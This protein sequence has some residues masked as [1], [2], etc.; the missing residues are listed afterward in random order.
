[1][2]RD[3]DIRWTTHHFLGQ[4]LL[5]S[6]KSQQR[7][8]LVHKSTAWWWFLFMGG[9]LLQTVGQLQE[10]QFSRWQTQTTSN[11]VALHC[12]PATHAD[13]QASN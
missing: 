3:A 11:V 10:P 9:G 13:P 1:M 5:A 4:H 2:T 12:K 8:R 7:L 6:T